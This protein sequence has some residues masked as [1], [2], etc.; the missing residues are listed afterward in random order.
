MAR[1][2]TEASAVVVGG[3]YAGVMAAHR[4]LR[5]ARLTV[6]LVNEHPRFVDR[7]RLHQHVT[8]TGD[9]E[10]DYGTLLHPRL[11]LVVGE[12]VRIDVA[13]RAVELR[14]GP[15]L[16]YDHLVYA[17]G[18]RPG[19]A[20]VRGVAEHAY[21]VASLAA[22]ERLRAALREA[23]PDAPVTVVG[24]G[25]TG[26]ETAAELAELGHQVTLVGGEVLGP[27]LHEAGRRAALRALGDLGVRVLSGPGARVTEVR[28][29]EVVL[30][31]GRRLPSAVTAWTT[32][33]VVPELARA[34][35]LTTDQAGRLLTDETLTSV[36][37]A[38]IVGA[39]DAVSPSGTPLRMSC[40]A[41][42]PLG[43]HAADTVLRR[44]SGREPRPIEVGFV[45]QCT[46]LGRGRGVLQLTRP[47]DSPR[48][49]ALSGRTAVVAKELACRSVI[50]GLKAEGRWPGLFRSARDRSRSTRVRTGIPVD[51]ATGAPRAGG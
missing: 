50:A 4:L 32:G 21:P 34:S 7:I 40:Q 47:D 43:T 45:G 35:G 26:I 2:S 5:N 29:D 30:E 18:S 22:A 1:S 49:T 31:D 33:F 38:R 13:R 48:A 19:V 17:V 28:P 46:S 44:M 42:M 51:D 15:A 16:G 6:T 9:A 20:E 36:D 41:A 39:G 24:G 23:G 8:G 27:S 37:D 11:R 14:S 3:G 25:L 10:R 12:A